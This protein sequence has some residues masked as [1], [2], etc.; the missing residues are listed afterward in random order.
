MKRLEGKIAIVTGGGSGI[1]RGIAQA[2]ADE[3]ASVV[4]CGRRQ[5]RLEETVES[6][7]NQGG[8]ALAV[9]AD[10]SIEK[11]IK[12]LVRTTLDTYDRIDILVNNAGVGGGDDT[13]LMDVADWDYVMSVNLRGV[14]LL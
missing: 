7:R 11:D 4:I 6:I 8:E 2:L 10:V 3:G 1:G 5:H 12:R 13:H 9:Q 14:F